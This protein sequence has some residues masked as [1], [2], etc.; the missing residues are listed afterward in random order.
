MVAD[1]YPPAAGQSY[2][3]GP[4]K[5]W[6]VIGAFILL[7]IGASLFMLTVEIALILCL[8]LLAAGSLYGIYR[9]LRQ[10]LGDKP[11]LEK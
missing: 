1:N 2:R 11:R 9:V 3:S 10:K 6:A 5:K 8:P 7:L 4:A